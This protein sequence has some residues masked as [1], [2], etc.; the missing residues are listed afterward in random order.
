MTPPDPAHDP[1]VLDLLNLGAGDNQSRVGLNIDSSVPYR[2]H[3][4]GLTHWIP[5]ALIGRHRIDRLR[6]LEGPMR[7]HDLRRGIPLPD[8]S[9]RAVYHQ[10]LL[11]HMERADAPGLMKEIHRVLVPGGLHRIC[12]PD[13]GRRVDSYSRSC[14]RAEAGEITAAEHERTVRAMLEQCVRVRPAALRGKSGIRA[15]IEGWILGDAR[16]RKETH[17]WMYDRITL[18]GLLA[19][20]GFTDIHVA[21]PGCSAIPGWP[22]LDLEITREGREK[23]PGSLYM[24]ARKP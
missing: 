14:K 20:A 5:K 13:L 10:H 7:H 12:L 1:P 19:E 22:A 21:R 6:A 17:Q 11:E 9:V 8:G 15:A 23:R 3:A 24:E 2:L 18:G 16:R 4:L